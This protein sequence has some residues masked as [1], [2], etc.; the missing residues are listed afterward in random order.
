[1]IELDGE[2]DEGGEDGGEGRW[3]YS[4]RDDQGVPFGL[5]E[6]PPS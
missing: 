6:V 2:V 3:L 1:V 4:C 5:R